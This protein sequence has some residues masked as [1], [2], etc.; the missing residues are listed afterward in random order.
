MFLTAFYT[1]LRIGELCGMD[2]EQI[3]TTHHV[4]TVDRQWN[5]KEKKI[6]SP[7][8]RRIRH[9]GMIPE[10]QEVLY[11]LKGNGSVFKKLTGRNLVGGKLLPNYYRKEILP[12]ACERAQVKNI[13]PHG[14]RHSF[15]ALWL[16]QGGSLQSLQI[17][18]GH[19]SYRTTEDSYGHLN[20]SHIRN[21]MEIISQV[22]NVTHVDFQKPSWGDWAHDTCCEYV[23]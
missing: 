23:P 2:W 4:L 22:G 11:P 9:L 19:R 10:V 6:T 7:K 8:G 17:L 13:G 20:F 18:L 3:D 15:A 14:T 5:E 16:I 12:G 1:G 21:Q